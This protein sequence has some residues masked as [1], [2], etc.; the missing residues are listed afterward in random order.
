MAKLVRL[1]EKTYAD[2][3]KT[4]GLLQA[5][6]GRV[7]SLDDATAYLCARNSG[8]TRVFLKKFLEK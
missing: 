1:S 2:L 6:A 5:R 7:V 3:S 8:R 4:A